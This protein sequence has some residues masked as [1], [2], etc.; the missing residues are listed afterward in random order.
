MGEHDVIFVFLGERM[1]DVNEGRVVREEE[2]SRCEFG[3]M[4]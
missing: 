1:G 4:S 3:L 2:F